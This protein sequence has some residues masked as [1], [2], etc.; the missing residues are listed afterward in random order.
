MMTGIEH[1]DTVNTVSPTYAREILLPSDH[2]RGYYG[3]EGLETLIHPAD[4]EKRLFGILNGCDYPQDRPSSLLSV[5]ELWEVLRSEV[6]S[7]KVKH[8][9]PYYDTLLEKLRRTSG[10]TPGVILTTVTRIVDQKI[11]LLYEHTGNGAPALDQI[12]KIVA[13]YNGTFMILGS[14]GAEYERRLMESAQRYERLLFIRGYSERIADALYANGT[15]FLMPSSFEPCG[16]SQMIAMREGQ[17]CVVHAV[18]GLKDTVRHGV[19]GFTFSGESPVEQA[20]NF[21]RGVKE[22]LNIFTRQPEEW[23]RIASAAGKERFTW[24]N[25]AK[26]YDLLMYPAR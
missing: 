12:M 18:G 23:K 14:G 11:R 4:K 24:E 2:Q 15:L 20:D 21:V 26:Q 19:T 17:P 5:P 6:Q 13:E 25:S 9:D 3:G 8:N 22:A 1:A 7:L 16:I 10:D